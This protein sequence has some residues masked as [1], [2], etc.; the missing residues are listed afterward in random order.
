MLGPVLSALCWSSSLWPQRRLLAP[1]FRNLCAPSCLHFCASTGV[2]VEVKTA[3]HERGQ[4]RVCFEC[5]CQQQRAFIA[6]LAV[7]LF[8]VVVLSLCLL[9]MLAANKK[10]PTPPKTCLLSPALPPPLCSALCLHWKKELRRVFIAA[11]TK[12]GRKLLSLKCVSVVHLLR[13][14]KSL[15]VLSSP[16]CLPNSLRRETG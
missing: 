11:H 7:C 9:G 13:A 1:R 4:S 14:R 10:D 16:S 3:Q 12:Q 2:C 5:I 15:A 6:K 8:R